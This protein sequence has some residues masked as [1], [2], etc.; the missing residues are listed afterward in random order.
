MWGCLTTNPTAQW[1]GQQVVSA[2]P[3]DAARPSLIRDR[4]RAY[5]RAQAQRVDNR[6]IPEIRTAVRAP[7]MHAF[8]ER[9]VGT[10]RCECFAT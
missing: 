9:V 2:F 6:G 4:D 1:L 5:G 10:L 8:A 3:W 7:M